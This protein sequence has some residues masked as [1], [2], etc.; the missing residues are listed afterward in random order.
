MIWSFVD[1]DIL[2]LLR[3]KGIESIFRNESMK[4]SHADD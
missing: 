3:G 1:V 4:E 2:W